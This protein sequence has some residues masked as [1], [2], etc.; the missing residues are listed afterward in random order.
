MTHKIA[1]I[2]VNFRVPGGLY[3]GMRRLA[4]W[5]LG[6]IQSRLDRFPRLPYQPLPWLGL[7][8]ADR[9]T[10]TEAR[11]KEIEKIA[12]DHHI[13]TAM[14]LGSNVGYF[15]FRL[16]EL[17]IGTIGFEMSGRFYRLAL[18]AAETFSTNRPMFINHMMT[19]EDKHALPTVDMVLVLSVWHHWVRAF[20]LD[21][22]SLMLRR[23]WQH[24][25]V[26][27]VFE[28]GESEMPASYNLPAM[29]PDARAWLTKYLGD[30]MEGAKV[31]HLGQFKAFS[32]GGNENRRI[33]LRN[34]FLVS[35]KL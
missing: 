25:N 2:V 32:P 29:V 34:L 33:V 31:S 7:V 24:C 9:A 12:K 28:T 6:L 4:Q 1:P 19:P 30:I 35:R 18:Q 8:D 11:W 15:C 13:K 26:A 17:G 27:M 10:G 14:D 22:A 3:M 5:P 21:G 16:S 20:G 23:A